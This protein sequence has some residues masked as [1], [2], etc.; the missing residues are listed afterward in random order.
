[1]WLIIYVQHLLDIRKLFST[2]MVLVTRFNKRKI[3]IST[4]CWYTKL[5][6][7]EEHLKL[8]RPHLMQWSYSRN[9]KIEDAM[10]LE[11]DWMEA[12]NSIR[13]G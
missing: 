13:D 9:D 11:G 1:M 12:T 10:A 5:H 2:N 8:Y 6:K 4:H 7:E 3:R